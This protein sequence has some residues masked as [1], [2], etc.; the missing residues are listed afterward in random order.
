MIMKQ[1]NLSKSLIAVI[2]VSLLILLSFCN[3]SCTKMVRTSPGNTA[4]PKSI[5][6]DTTGQTGLPDQRT[7]SWRGP[8]EYPT[9]EPPR[10]DM[11]PAI[12]QF[13]DLI[14]RVGDIRICVY[15][16]SRLSD[17]ISDWRIDSRGVIKLDIDQEGDP[18]LSGVSAPIKIQ[19]DGDVNLGDK[20]LQTGTF[21]RSTTAAIYTEIRQSDK[22]GSIPIDQLLSDKLESIIIK[23]FTDAGA[24]VIDKALLFRQEALRGRLKSINE[25]EIRALSNKVDVLLEVTFTPNHLTIEGYEINIKAVKVKD[26]SI[27]TSESTAM[28]DRLLAE[29]IE[30]IPDAG[31]FKKVR[32]RRY[33]TL[34]Y[35][36]QQVTAEVMI[37]MAR[38]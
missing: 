28:I 26:A 32:H 23:G 21:S 4:S 37:A 13:R 36:S 11:S 6:P 30:Y 3:W 25:T 9:Q 1:Q 14:R 16:N 10:F 8:V 34:E 33:A 29:N 27:I 2:S 24:K 38:Q 22:P 35:L 12:I 19:A 31:G 5:K 18:S 7:V 20:S 15:Y 17:Q